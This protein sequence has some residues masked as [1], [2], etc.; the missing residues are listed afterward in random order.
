MKKGGAGGET[1]TLP[2]REE[3]KQK[4]GTE[5]EQEN[6]I[7]W[8]GSGQKDIKYE[9]RPTQMVS[10]PGWDVK[11]RWEDL[12]FSVP[13]LENKFS[14]PGMFLHRDFSLFLLF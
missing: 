8:W 3:S 1:R 14:G 10:W 5:C 13:H 7:T 4:D 9:W 12:Y 2:V 11:R 6:F